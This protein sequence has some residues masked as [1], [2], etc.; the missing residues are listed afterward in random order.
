MAIDW[1]DVAPLTGAEARA[2][3]RAGAWRTKTVGM[4]QGRV[5]A[6]LVVLPQ[7]YAADFQRFCE[8]NGQACPL[9]D[10]TAP[11]SAEPQRVAPGADVRTDVPRYR[12]YR[13]GA[14]AAEVESLEPYW[15]DDLVAFLLGCSFTF[16]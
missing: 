11:G 14:V 5:Q 6:N 12:V 16:E 3:I 4:A 15:R 10:V 2:R 1:T 7:T 9:L 13:E 8:A